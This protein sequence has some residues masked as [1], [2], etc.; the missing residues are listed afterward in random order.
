MQQL[1]LPKPSTPSAVAVLASRHPIF[2]LRGRKFSGDIKE[3][4]LAQEWLKAQ[5]EIFY[6]D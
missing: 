4:E 6:S 2:T 3:K 5:T 1:T